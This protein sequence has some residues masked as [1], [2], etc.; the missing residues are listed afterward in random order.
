MPPQGRYKRHMISLSILVIVAFAGTLA[1]YALRVSDDPAN[2]NQETAAVAIAT[3][4][5]TAPLH[6]YLTDI[7]KVSM[8]AVGDIML[9]RNVETLREKNGNNYPFRG[10]AQFLW[11]SDFVLGNLEGPIPGAAKHTK[12]ANGSMQF[13]FDDSVPP[14]LAAFNV[15]AVALANNHMYDQGKDGY[16][17]TQKALE[18]HEI[19]WFG[20]PTETSYKYTAHRSI[21]GERFSFIGLN[22]VGIEFNPKDASETIARAKKEKNSFVV[23]AIHWG[24]E[25][26]TTTSATQRSLAHAL[27]DAGADLIIGSHPHV[28]QPLE[29]YHDKPIFYSLGNFIFDQYFNKEVES[30]LSVKISFFPTEIR[31]DLFPTKSYQ[32]QPALLTGDDRDVWLSSF[33]ARALKHLTLVSDIFSDKAFIAKNGAVI[34]DPYL[35]AAGA[36]TETVDAEKDRAKQFIKDIGRGYFVVKRETANQ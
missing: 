35:A 20:N 28:V 5:T 29:L 24:D 8:V 2:A 7:P 15:W 27:V 31:Y 3:S 16:A 36:S 19:T 18:D 14:L 21:N 25:Y 32:S 12:T 22:T 26:A 17:N 11:N 23:V 6:E 34:A 1:L 10:A 30:G 13:S 9:G 33:A 4:T